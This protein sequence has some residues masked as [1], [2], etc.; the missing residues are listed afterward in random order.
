MNT[1]RY[2]QFYSPAGF[3]RSQ[4]GNERFLPD[5]SVPKM[6]TKDSCRICPFPKW[7]RKIPAGFAR[8]Y[9]DEVRYNI[10]Y[11]QFLISINLKN[12]SDEQKSVIYGVACNADV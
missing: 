9:M 8:A 11:S 7:E 6:G 2:T 3:A 10:E 4:S 1:Q 5:L 12:K